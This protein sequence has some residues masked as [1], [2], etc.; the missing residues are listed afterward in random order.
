M[1]Y[2]TLSLP[3]RIVLAGVPG[4][5][6]CGGGG[7]GGGC[8]RGGGEDRLQHYRNRSSGLFRVVV[9]QDL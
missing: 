2:A 3:L 5:V 8:N 7:E 9:L 6:R 1:R 4:V